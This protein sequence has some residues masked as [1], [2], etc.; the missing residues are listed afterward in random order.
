MY[1]RTKT[2]SQDD[3]SNAYSKTILTLGR[4]SCKKRKVAT[5]SGLILEQRICDAGI[6]YIYD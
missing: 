4:F 6:S 2:I 1:D 5:K 3:V